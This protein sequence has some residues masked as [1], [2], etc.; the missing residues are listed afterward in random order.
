MNDPVKIQKMLTTSEAVARMRA[1]GMVVTEA[2]QPFTLPE[3]FKLPPLP[4][5][6]TMS[7]LVIEMRL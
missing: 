3:L 7:D 4:N 6:Q 1:A 2:T 5:G